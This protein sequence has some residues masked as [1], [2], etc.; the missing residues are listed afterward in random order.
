MTFWLHG[1]FS[2]FTNSN[3]TFFYHR[4]LC[5]QSVLY[6][7][8]LIVFV[9]IHMNHNCYMNLCKGLVFDFLRGIECIEFVCN[10]F[11]LV[12]VQIDL[13]QFEKN[14]LD[15]CGL[16]LIQIHYIQIQ[17]IQFRIKSDT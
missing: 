10:K 6:K 15:Q 9:Q 3:Y 5:I 17:S 7:V 11:V 12:L 8:V 13:I 1:Y 16:K 2:F 4:E 14:V